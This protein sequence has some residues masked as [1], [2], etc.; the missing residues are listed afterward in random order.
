MRGRMVRVG[1]LRRPGAESCPNLPQRPE[2]SRS[3]RE[4][5]LIF[6][7]SS[8][9][10]S[11]RGA[12]LQQIWTRPAPDRLRSHIHPTASRGSP[13]GAPGPAAE[14]VLAW[15]CRQFAPGHTGTGRCSDPTPGGKDPSFWPAFE[16]NAIRGARVFHPG[17]ADPCRRGVPHPGSQFRG[18]SLL[19]QSDQPRAP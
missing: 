11:R 5:T 12:P 10:R 16:Y 8:R 19:R 6:R 9:G 17:P 15:L 7:A 18:N 14:E 13:R 3:A 1:L 2:S 4:E